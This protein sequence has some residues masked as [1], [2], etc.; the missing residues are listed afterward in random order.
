MNDICVVDMSVPVEG[1]FYVDIEMLQY[2]DHSHDE[3]FLSI[4]DIQTDFCVY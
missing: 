1:G 4:A 3:I 2:F